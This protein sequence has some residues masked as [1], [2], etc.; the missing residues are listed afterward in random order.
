MRA[1]KLVLMVTLMMV[2]APVLAAT[3]A[4]N[5]STAPPVGPTA[6]ASGSIWDAPRAILFDNG[7]L[8]NS[9]GT[10][11]GG[12]DE[13]VLQST[14]LGMNTL[15]FGFQVSAGNQIA[16]DF[17]IPPGE[18][19]QIDTI[20]TFGYQSGAGTPSTITGVYMQIY[21]GQPGAGGTVVWGDLTTNRLS[22]TSWTN[23]YR[24]TETTTGGNTD[25]AI[26]ANVAT[27]N[28]TLTAGTYWI[29]WT[30]DGSSSFSGPWAPPVTINGQ[31]ST[32]NA[33]QYTT[34][35]GVW[36]PALD[37]G[38]STQQGFP[39]IIDGTVLGG[40]GGGGGGG[41]VGAAG[42]PIP[43]LSKT[44]VVVLMLALI[45]IAAILIRRRM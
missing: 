7:P 1:T 18:T 14:S 9:P 39:F 23:I 32:G 45:G 30:T 29:E 35:G 20:T 21:D 36:A 41:G 42:E 13:S 17:T 24:V 11:V 19:W 16:D 26:M 12:A 3:D 40:G 38:T 22:T 10:G 44:G 31:T 5:A 6:P 37:S 8:V 15:G 28:T 34:S 2:A 43:T 25:R 33:V 4:E 27:V